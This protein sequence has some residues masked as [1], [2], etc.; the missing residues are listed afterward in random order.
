MLLKKKVVIKRRLQNIAISIGILSLMALLLGLLA[1]REY[2]F[3]FLPQ[4]FSF[5]FIPLCCMG[6]NY[7]SVV[8]GK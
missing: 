2:S 4:F 1:G 8:H 5:Y 6:F 3:F 7:V